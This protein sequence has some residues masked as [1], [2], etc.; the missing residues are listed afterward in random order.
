MRAPRVLVLGS[1]L[2]Q[3]PGGVRRHNEELLPR[4]AELLAER[5]GELLVLEGRERV[6]FQ[7]PESVQVLRSDI[8]AY[9]PLARVR[10]ENRL[11]GALAHGS[12]DLVHGAHLPLAGRHAL[13]CT[14]LIHDLRRLD[15]SF[16]SWLQRWFARTV[17]ARALS[18]ASGLAVV[19]EAMRRELI[20]RMSIPSERIALIPNAADHL[21]VLERCST[22]E[23]SLITLGHLEPRKNLELLLRALAVDATLPPLEIHGA[24][25]GNEGA[26][27]KS[28]AQEL[29][30]AGR[31]RFLG[32]IDEAALPQLYARAAAAVFPARIEGF[33][34]GALEASQAGCPVAVSAIA[35]HREIVPQAPCF[36]P[37]DARDCARAIRRALHSAAE[38]AR[39]GPL[40]ARR[41]SWDRSAAAL[42]DFW[43]RAH[44]DSARNRS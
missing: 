16:G 42:A 43:C 44:A 20:Q 23:S 6:A 12:C 39:S 34:I 9:P 3:P 13:P 1:V 28:L 41:Y 26:R 5:G 35:A 29:G 21:P 24:E 25:K 11:L 4:V 27:L 17:L 19:S 8:P 10:A 30:V 33:G 38:A 15:P 18:R 7:L 40:N 22:E 36:D 32:P 31:V 14:L 2:G 37:G